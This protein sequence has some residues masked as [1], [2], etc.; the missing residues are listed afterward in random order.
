LAGF[1]IKRQGWGPIAVEPNNTMLYVTD[2]INGNVWQLPTTGGTATL[3][4]TGL[5]EVRSLAV[6]ATSV[7]SLMP[8]HKRSSDFRDAA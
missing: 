7:S 2:V 1:R 4:A 6:D 8:P 3:F 5:R